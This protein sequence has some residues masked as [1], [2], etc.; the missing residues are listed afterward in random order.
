MHRNFFTNK[1][2]SVI[3]FL[4]VLKDPTYMYPNVFRGQSNSDW[5]L[6]PSIERFVDKLFIRNYSLSWDYFQNELL[7]SF[8][9][10]SHPFLDFQP[11]NELDWLVHAQHHGLPTILLDWTTN[12]LKAL[13]FAVQEDNGFDGSVFIGSAELYES[14]FFDYENLDPNSITFFN[15]KHI[16]QRVVSQEGCF[17]IL[18][19]P[20]KFEPF[21][22]FLYSDDANDGAFAFKIIV[23]SS[24][25]TAIRNELRILGINKRTIFP[26]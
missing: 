20:E 3:Q 21:K 11:S 2:G 23:D 9:R 13:Y 10:E 4:N 16:N 1:V 6:S 25:K 18:T 19:P 7:A 22:N 26:E 12:P 17:S 14:E 15:P 24:C 5:L 8:K